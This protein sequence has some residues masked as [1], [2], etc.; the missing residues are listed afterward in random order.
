MANGNI[1]VEGLYQMIKDVKELT[2]QIREDV[3]ESVTEKD[4]SRNHELIIQD[5]RV[6]EARVEALQNR[7]ISK[8]LAGLI[9][10]LLA[11]VTFLLGVVVSLF[12]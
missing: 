11:F 8:S 1:T 4:C 3:K 5:I 2:L 6:L 7:S 10:F 9:S 12:L